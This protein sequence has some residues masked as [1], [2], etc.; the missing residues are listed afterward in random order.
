MRNNVRIHHNMDRKQSMG[1]STTV[2]TEKAVL[3]ME[4][5]H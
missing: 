1:G 5:C 3:K 2:Y 4:K